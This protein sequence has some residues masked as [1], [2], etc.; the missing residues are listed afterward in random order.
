MS[1]D[2]P[3]PDP[4]TVG[5][6]DASGRAWVVALFGVGGGAFGALLPLLAR[7]AVQ[8][9]WMP[10]QGP[11][12][13]LGSFDQAWL[14]WLRPAV[15]L[16]LGLAFAA[17]V[18]MNSP[19][20]HI[21]GHQVRVERQGSIDRAIDRDKVDAVYR[22]GSKLIIESAAGRTLFADDVEGDPD[23]VRDAFLAHGYPWEGAP[24]A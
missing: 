13:L 9:P 16:L 2:S 17:W 5:G 6:F 7:L 11:L 24:P 1:D 15:G 3:T 10:F 14:T 8:L 23:A 19:R 22:R 4:S 18:I 20:L 21:D 12:Q